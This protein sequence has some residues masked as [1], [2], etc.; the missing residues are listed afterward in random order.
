MIPPYCPPECK[1]VYF[2]YNVRFD[3]QA[4][5][6]DCEPRRFRIAVEKA[7]YKEG[8]L[9]G[10]WQTMPVPAQDIFQQQAGLRRFELSLGSQRGQGH[11]LRLSRRRLS[12]GPDAVRHLHRRA[13]HPRA[14]R[15]DLMAK[16]VDAFHKVF[17]NLDQ[18]LDHADD[19]IYPGPDGALYGAG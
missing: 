9:V 18:A 8:V 2:M 3:P 13:R 16:I 10:Q 12:R 11:S 15:R 14:Q 1:H 6:V 17:D 5:G 19:E 4:A 7:L